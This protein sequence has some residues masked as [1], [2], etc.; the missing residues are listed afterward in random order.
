MQK[1]TLLVAILLLFAALPGARAGDVSVSAGIRISD[2]SVKG[3]HLAVSN[4][5]R[6]EERTVLLARKRKI[7]DDH[8]PV[9]FFLA[10]RAQVSPDVIVSLRLGGMSWMAI[11]AKY[12][13]TAGI[14]HVPVTADYGPPYGR[15]LG[16]FK[17]RKRSAWGKI[18][19]ADDDIVS[20][21]NI[22]FLAAHHG[23]TPDAVIKMR[24][25]GDGFIQ[26]HGRAKAHRAKVKAQ[27]AAAKRHAK[28]ASPGK[29]P[30][31]RAHK[32]PRHSK[33]FSQRG[34]GKRGGGGRGKRK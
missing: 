2:S 24:Q 32:A 1:A 9:V 28:P 23:C 12:G 13:L 20:L 5:Y 8:L 14:Y 25:K 19:L 6:V 4:H 29:K 17:N 15:A 33:P 27:H 18:Q 34:G 11:T 16:H 22:K 3:F 10:Q 31:V 21:V 7:P 26:L 30:A